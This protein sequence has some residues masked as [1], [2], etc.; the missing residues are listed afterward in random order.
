MKKSTVFWMGLAL[1]SLGIVIGFCCSPVREGVQVQIKNN[2]NN[3]NQFPK[4][5]AQ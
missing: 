2:G 1:L 4:E 5:W 3:H